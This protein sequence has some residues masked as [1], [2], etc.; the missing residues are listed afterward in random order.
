[1]EEQLGSNVTAIKRGVVIGRLWCQLHELFGHRN[2]RG[3]S[4]LLRLQSIRIQ[5]FFKNGS[6]DED[7]SVQGKGY[8]FSRKR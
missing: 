1:M 2:G 5:G 6:V 3:V 7:S 4:Y 8:G